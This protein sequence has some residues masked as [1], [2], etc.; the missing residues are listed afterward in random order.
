MNSPDKSKRGQQDAQSINEPLYQE[1]ASIWRCRSSTLSDLHISSKRERATVAV[2]WDAFLLSFIESRSDPSSGRTSSMHY[3][4]R[5]E[6]HVSV[7]NTLRYDALTRSRVSNKSA[8]SW[9]SCLQACSNVNMPARPMHCVASGLKS[10]HVAA[11]SKSI[12]A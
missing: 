9:T 6:Y 8:R 5:K 4:F 1:I 3:E 12:N 7:N 11:V 2:G 10:C